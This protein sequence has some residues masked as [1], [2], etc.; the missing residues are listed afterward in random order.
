MIPSNIEREHIVKA[1]REID[2]NNIPPGRQPKIFLLIFE[3][4]QYTP[5]YVLSLANKFANGEELDPSRFG[6]GQETNNFLR[7]L[8][9]DI[10]SLKS[11]T[12][13]KPESSPK[14]TLKTTQKKHDERCPECKKTIERMLKTIYGNVNSNYKFEVSTNVEDYK[15][16]A[17]YEKLKEIHLE[18]SKFRGYNDFVRTPTLPHCDFFVPNPG[19]VVEF[20]ESQ[21]FTPLRKISLQKYPQNLE[22][23]FSSTKWIA[24]CEKIQAKDNDPP[25]RDEQRAWYDTL[26]DF[27]PVMKGLRPTVRLFARDIEWCS[28]NPD[29]PLDI[30]RFTNLLERR[31][32]S[33]KI[34]VREETNPFL[35]R[36]IIAGEWNGNPVDAKKLLEDV[37]ETWSNRERVKFVIT[38]GGFI[39]FDW[40]KSVTPR[41][42]GDNRNPHE[43]S[44]NV[45]VKEAEKCAKFILNDGLDVKLGKITDYITL[46]IDS[47]KEKIST[48]KNYISQPHIELVFLVDLRNN[49]F[50]WTGKSYPTSSQQKGLVRIPDM[51]KHFFNFKDTGNVMVLGC[52]D[53]TVFNPR[54]KNASGWRAKVNKEFR[55]LAQ[56]KKPVMVLHHPHTTDSVLTWAAAWSGLKKLLPTVKAYASAGRHY[57]PDGERSKLISVLEKTKSGDTIDFIVTH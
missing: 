45:L 55:E 42:I 10:R 1:I 14:R 50:Y 32:V 30:K 29:N 3:G 7:D 27:L 35:A 8:G 38:C 15:N 33:W 6:G 31:T 46:G 2:S 9:F 13:T 56:E 20:D 43:D 5:K 36:I 41:D 17:F 40:P 57:N 18:L 44:V 48:T 24:L 4:K 54:S 12:S 25:F 19:F 34:E 23:G 21:H 16:L 52:H 26:R 47:Y 37:C 53:L 49:E 11:R 51:G 22:L 39:Q 28:L